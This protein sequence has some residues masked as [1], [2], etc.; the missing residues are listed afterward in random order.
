M[1]GV[2][3]RRGLFAVGK[4]VEQ[5]IFYLKR[6]YFKV[7]LCSM[8]LASDHRSSIIFVVIKPFAN[9]FTPATSGDG[10]LLQS[11]TNVVV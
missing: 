2:W 3:V 5:L 10:Y 1:I 11:A 7:C 8:L 4:S 9:G 6:S